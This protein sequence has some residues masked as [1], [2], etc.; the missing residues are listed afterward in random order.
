MKRKIMFSERHQ[1]AGLELWTLKK[2]TNIT[3]LTRAEVTVRTAFDLWY[4]HCSGKQLT[5]FLDAI[6][7]T[8]RPSEW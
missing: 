7:D 4:F 2:G 5:T 1:G 3:G 6:L 8:W